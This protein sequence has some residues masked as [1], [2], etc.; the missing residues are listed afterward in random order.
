MKKTLLLVPLLTACGS[1][2][3]P[4]ADMYDLDYRHQ[5]YVRERQ[6]L[7]GWPIDEVRHIYA[8]RRGSFCSD[9]SLSNENRAWRCIVE[10]PVANA[11]CILTYKYNSTTHIVMEVDVQGTKEACSRVI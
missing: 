6:R 4:S 11:H 2:F 7:V 1:I 9:I 5:M 8:T 10:N 3:D